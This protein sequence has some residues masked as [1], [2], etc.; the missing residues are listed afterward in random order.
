EGLGLLEGDYD[1]KLSA[2]QQP[3]AVS[4]PRRLPIPMLPLVKAEL[5][6]MEDLGVIVRVTDATEWCAPMVIAR[7]KNNEL[8]ICTSFERLN[9]NIIRERSIMPT[10]EE[11]LAGLSRARIF[12]KLD[13]CSGF[14]QVPLSPS[15]QRL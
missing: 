12:S 15:S 7:K 4:T 11:T 8:R 14:W 6:R 10:V 13:A 3:F 5:Q 9:Q 1:I 2:N